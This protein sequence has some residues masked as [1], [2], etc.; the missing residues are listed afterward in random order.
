MH[1]PVVPIKR[2]L[3]LLTDV[4]Q[5]DVFMEQLSLVI[6]MLDAL[7]IKVQYVHRWQ[8]DEIQQSLSLT[9]FPLETIVC[10]IEMLHCPGVVMR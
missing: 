1:L 6:K 9:S 7:L 8:W 3:L 2:V 4:Y 10:L 5:V